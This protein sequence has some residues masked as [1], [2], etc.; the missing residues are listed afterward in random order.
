MP[1]P[2]VGLQLAVGPAAY[3]KCALHAAPTIAQCTSTGGVIC[4]D[5]L[6]YECCDAGNTPGTGTTPCTGGGTVINTQTFSD[7]VGSGY[8]NQ[9]GYTTTCKC[10][11][12]IV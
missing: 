6:C 9:R 8:V 12:P 2:I 3:A 7:S 11:E 5:G 4:A 10:L 1:N